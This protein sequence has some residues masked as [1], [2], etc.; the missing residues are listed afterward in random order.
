[1]IVTSDAATL[2]TVELA[3]RIGTEFLAT[4]D[5]VLSGKHAA[6]VRETLEQRGVVVFRELHLTK[7]EQI[8]FAETLGVVKGKS[9]GGIMPI[10]LDKTINSWVAEYLKG[11]FYWH[12]DGA[13]D[14]IP[15]FAA[16]LNA[17]VLSPTGGATSFANTYAAWDDLPEAEQL[18]LYGVKVQHSFEI[19]QRYVNPTPT[20]EELT[21][22][23]K[24]EPK[25][26]P[27]VWTHRSGRKSLV[28]GSTAWEVQGMAP[29]EGRMLLCKLQEWATQPQFVYR[30][31]WQVGD[32]LIW[33]NTGTMHKVDP[34]DPE[35]GRMMS[36]TTLEGE[37]SIA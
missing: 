15:N 22:W 17:H 13:S 8:A 21:L 2:D 37:E 23:Q 11:S 7:P 34:Y 25:V 24:Y 12:I 28:L 4:K 33:D 36:R 10:T 32:L 31:E 20:V 26:H 9:Q 35:S 3:P 29:A 6:Q 5:D 1:M 18:Q 30:H 19:S 16:L 27:L 14:D